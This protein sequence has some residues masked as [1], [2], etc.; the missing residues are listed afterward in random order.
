MP[1][2]YLSIAEV[3]ATLS[4]QIRSVEKGES[5]L[6][7]RHG[8]AVA[9]LVPAENLETLERLRASGPEGGLASVAGGWEGS[10]ELV[11][12]LKTSPRIGQ[13]ATADLD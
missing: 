1:R 2:K 9:A 7:T 3:K 5:V 10:D 8:K 12:L 4:E 11:R 13:R 6:I